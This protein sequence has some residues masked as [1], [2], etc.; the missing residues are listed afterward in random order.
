MI[1]QQLFLDCDG[2]LADF[3]THALEVFGIPS[4]E[5]ER[6]YGAKAFWKRLRETPNYFRDMPLM[7]DARL[8][9]DEVQHLNPIILTGCPR[10]DWAQPQKTAWVEQHFPG[11]KMITCSSRDK[12]NH[13]KAGDVIVDDWH[14][15]RHLWLEMGGIW[16]SHTCA[17][18]SIDALS[19]L[20]VL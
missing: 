9:M 17:Q 13:A 15:Y 19:A 8:L 6:I 10:G 5:Y 4:R 12:R 2:V 14:Q 11:I 7:S 16:V 3:D 1:K 20:G 18:T